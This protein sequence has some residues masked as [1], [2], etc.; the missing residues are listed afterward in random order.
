MCVQR[1][2]AVDADAVYGDF[3]S[4]SDH[5]ADV[6][7]VPKRPLEAFM[8]RKGEVRCGVCCRRR[9]DAWAAALLPLLRAVVVV[10]VIV[11]VIVHCVVRRRCCRRSTAA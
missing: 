9:L 4:G 7:A 8:T 2:D 5:V 3:I 10:A 1:G 11:V 6:I